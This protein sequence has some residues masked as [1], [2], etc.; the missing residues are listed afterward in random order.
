VVVTTDVNGTTTPDNTFG[1]LVRPDGLFDEM[2]SLMKG[3]TSGSCKFSAVLPKM[4]QLAEGVDRSRL[5]SYARQMPLYGG[6]TATVDE[7]THSDNINAKVALC[8]TGFAGLMA[9]VNKFRHGYSL[10]VAASPVLVHLLSQEEKSCLTRPITDEEEKVKVIDDLVNSHR[11][12]MQLLFHVG[13]TMG[14]FP[15][16]KYAAELGGTGIAFDPNEPLKVSI[17]GLSGN[18]RKRICAVNFPSDEK[19]DYTKVGDVIRET[20]WKAVRVQV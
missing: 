19:P 4:K 9:L 12:N 1:E 15:A 7:V 17:S 6:V 11:P 13:D 8:T 5:E 10:I 16:I 20:V 14:D 18:L 2:E 3:Y